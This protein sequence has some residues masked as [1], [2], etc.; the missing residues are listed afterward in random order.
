MSFSTFETIFCVVIVVAY[1]LLGLPLFLMNLL[2]ILG[3]FLEDKDE[4]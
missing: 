4:E 3:H 2:F 1:I